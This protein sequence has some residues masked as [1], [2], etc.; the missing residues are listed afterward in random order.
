MV[1]LKFLR[2]ILDGRKK[3]LK[4]K[5]VLFLGG[6]ERYK[7]LKMEIIIPES[8]KEFPILHEYF[9]D[10]VNNKLIDRSWSYDVILIL[11]QVINTISEGW[12]ETR[13]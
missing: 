10:E 12:L 13:R 3:H 4:I 2:Q 8:L 1:K 6:Y 11:M 5:K 7:D 9:P